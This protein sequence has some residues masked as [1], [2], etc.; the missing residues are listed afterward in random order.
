[1]N[2]WIFWILV[3]ALRYLPLF[4]LSLPVVWPTARGLL[5]DTHAGVSSL[6]DVQRPHGVYSARGLAIADLRPPRC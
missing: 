3:R 5:E 6:L 1:M 2:I 4:F